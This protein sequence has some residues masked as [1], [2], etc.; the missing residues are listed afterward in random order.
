MVVGGMTQFLTSVQHTPAK[1]TKTLNKIIRNFFW[2]TPSP[3]P[4]A[5]KYLFLP[6]EEGGWNLLNIEARNDAIKLAK[7]KKLIDYGPNRAAWAD[8][9]VALTLAHLPKSEQRR[10][11][12]SSI[13]SPFLQDIYK[14][15][16][17]G[18]GSLP[19]E[20]ALHIICRCQV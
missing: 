3:P 17:H 4:V 2:G 15:S 8:A 18:H 16:H 7:L 1:V 6:A 19:D 11:D 20:L 5:E 9:A 12:A 10:G 14:R 13:I